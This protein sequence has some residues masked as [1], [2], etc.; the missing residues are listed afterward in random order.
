[1]AVDPDTIVAVEAKF[2]INP[3]RSLHEGKAPAFLWRDF[4]GELARYAKVVRH[5]D[6]P[7]GRLRIVANTRAAADVLGARARRIL[8]DDIDIDVRY[9]PEGDE[10]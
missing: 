6:N 10:P 3:G 8:G 4:D 9:E 2:V 1:L 5:P 7:V